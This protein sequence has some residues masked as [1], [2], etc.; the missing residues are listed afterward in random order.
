[1]IASLLLV[2]AARA[3]QEPVAKPSDSEPTAS[4]IITIPDGAP[5]QLRFARPVRGKVPMATNAVPQAKPTDTVRMVVAADVRVDNLVVIAKGTIGQVTV[6]KVWHPFM[7][8]TGLS[9]RFDWI[10]DVTGRTV[11][12]R[13][14]QKGKPEPFTVQVLSTYGGMIA[15]PETL[16][17]DLMGSDS[18]D[19]S[20][21]WRRKTWIPAG[22]RIQGF[23]Q[24]ANARDRAEVIDA[25]ALLPNSN[26]IATLTVYRTKGQDESRPRLICDGK[27]IDKIGAHQYATLELTPGKHTCQAEHDPTLEIVAHAGETLPEVQINHEA[28]NPS[29]VRLGTAVLTLGPGI[30]THQTEKQGHSKVESARPTGGKSGVGQEVGVFGETPMEGEQTLVPPTNEGG[31]ALAERIHAGDRAA[32][33]ELPEN[34]EFGG[35]PVTRHRD[36]CR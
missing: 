17:G 20:L 23:V 13:A 35:G 7:A 28:K 32:E 24:G 8:L 18:M 19:I 4:N 34:L 1:V 26:E 11:L 29:L 9:L 36:V 25:Q 14:I 12:L 5:V 6:V 33:D 2:S 3:Q 27:E 16:R 31:S 22:T 10:K 21:A 30:Q 15:R